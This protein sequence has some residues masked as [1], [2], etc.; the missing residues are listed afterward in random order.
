M[1]KKLSLF[2]LC[3]ATLFSTQVFSN[4]LKILH[5][6]KSLVNP[7]NPD[8]FELDS[9]GEKFLMQ[10]FIKNDFVVFDVGANVG[11]WS[12]NA[13]H[14]NPTIKLFSFEPT[15]D[16]YQKLVNHLNHLP[17]HFFELA[18]SSNSGQQNLYTHVEGFSGLNSLYYRRDISYDRCVNDN[19]V[20]IL[21][22]TVD[23]F[24]LN[25]GL[26]KIDFLKIDTEGS[27]LDVLKG[28][29]KMLQDHKITGIQFEYGGTYHAAHITLREVC[30]LLTQNGYCIFRIRP[31][32]LLYL[33]HWKDSLENYAG[34]NLF[35]IL[36][37]EVNLPLMTGL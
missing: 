26:D 3:I 29:Q 33:K 20:Q 12:I 17:I 9:N 24:C 35:A 31:A 23:N 15:P 10:T 8:S 27:E 5:S 11:D 7:N 16:I 36:Q 32:G 21:T 4:S 30:T 34:K 25:H 2:I 6:D 22:D 14:V 1:T 13:Y 19:S 37:S 18:F 28:S